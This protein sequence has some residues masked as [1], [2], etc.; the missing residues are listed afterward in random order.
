MEFSIRKNDG[1]YK[2]NQINRGVTLSNSTIFEGDCQ[3]ETD[4]LFMGNVTV[5]S[6]TLVG[7]RNILWGGD[8]TIGRYCQLA[9]YVAI[10]AKDHSL[11]TLTAYNNR[12]LFDYR[13]KQLDEYKPVTICDDV[14]IGVGST[15]LSGVTIGPGSIIGA[16]SVVTKSLPEYVIAAGN[17]AKVIKKRFS[18]ELISLLMQWKWWN[19]S[20]LE[21]LPY[22]D[23]FFIN[24]KESESE[25]IS[26]VKEIIKNN[27]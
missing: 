13:L 26:R 1:R 21:L 25:M 2:R 18:D 16:G 27:K 17:P 12:R 19:L 15:I 7:T 5:K 23:L 14:W 8:I 24:L 3:I 4:S 10:Y 20:P 9:P 22:E 6:Y 11:Q